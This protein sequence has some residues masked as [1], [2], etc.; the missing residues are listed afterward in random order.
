MILIVHVYGV[1]HNSSTLV[2]SNTIQTVKAITFRFPGAYFA[3]GTFSLT[4][5]DFS[6][7]HKEYGAKCSS[8]CSVEDWN[9]QPQPYR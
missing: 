9:G 2:Y 6:E 3:L 1:Q 5:E 7:M 4:L 8:G